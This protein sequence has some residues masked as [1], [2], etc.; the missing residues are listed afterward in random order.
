MSG[1]SLTPNRDAAL[2]ATTRMRANLAAAPHL[3][4]EF[5]AMQTDISQAISLAVADAIDRGANPNDA[6]DLSRVISGLTAGIASGIASVSAFMTGGADRGFPLSF[7]VLALVRND[8][9]QLAAG[10]RKVA[11]AP[12]DQTKPGRA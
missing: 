8:L 7:A 3:S 10:Q 2:E 1:P 5:R 12:V 6:D 11:R 9:E 4:H